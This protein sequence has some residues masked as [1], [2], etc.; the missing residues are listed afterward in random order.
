MKWRKRSQ[1]SNGNVTGGYLD[2][3]GPNEYLVRSLGRVQAIEDLQQ[4]VVKIRD[5]RPVL[6]DQVARVV[7]GPQVKRG[8]SSAYVARP[9]ASSPAAPQSC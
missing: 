9:T 2:G 7:E 1:K 3:Q 4:L 8:D 5:G 6:L